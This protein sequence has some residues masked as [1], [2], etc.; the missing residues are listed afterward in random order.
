MVP[1]PWKSVECTLNTHC[2]GMEWWRGPATSLGNRCNWTHFQHC[3]RNSAKQHTPIHYLY[4]NSLFIHQFIIYTPIHYLYT[5]SLLIHQF[6]IYTP[7]HYLHT[8]SLFIHQFIIYTPIH[9]LHT[10][11][12]IR[13]QFIIYTPIHTIV[14]KKTSHVRGIVHCSSTK[15][16][17]IAI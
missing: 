8:N 2:D 1:E 17:H 16:I 12:L 3:L 11:S 15:C 9:Y 4:T 14:W 10:N 6:I 13:H 7:I 5:N